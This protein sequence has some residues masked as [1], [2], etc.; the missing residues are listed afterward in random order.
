MTVTTDTKIK[1][2]HL[3]DLDSDAELVERKLKKS[4]L[5]FELLLVDNRVDFEKALSGFLPDIILSDHSL[6]NFN[7]L[8]ALQIMKDHG[9]KVPF[10]LITATV[11][12]DFAVEVMK[13]GAEDYI[14]KDR[15]QRLPAAI[16]KALEVTRLEKEEKEAIEKINK[17]KHLY[18]FISQVNQNIVHLDDEG[19]LFR[20]ACRLA[21]DFGK[22]KMAWIGLIDST[23]QSIHL[24]EQCGIPVEELALFAHA[25][26]DDNG[27]QSYV[28]RTGN[29]YISNN[30][31]HDIQLQSW[32]P[33][34]AKH[35]ICSCMVLP[36][37]KAGH[38]IGTLNLYAAELNF[39]AQEEIS[40]LIEVAADISFALDSFEKEKQH[41]IA[42]ALIIKSEKRFRH[43]LDGMMEGVQ[44]HDFNW[45]YIYVNDALVKDST[46]LK[47]QLLGHTLMEKYPGIEQTKL[48]T[49]LQRC[50]TSRVTE[51]L[52]SEF[53]FPNGTKAFFELSIQPI[54]EGIFILSINITERKKTAEKI[55]VNEAKYRSVVENIHES[56]I[57]EDAEGKLLYANNE[58]CN[59]FGFK[60]FELKKLTLKDYTSAESYPEII[61]RHKNRIE[62]LP[63]AEEFVYKGRRKDGTEIWVEA[64]VSSILEN[65]KIIGTQSLERDI[66]GRRQAE[67]KIV[68]TSRLYAFISSIN[69]SIVHVENEQELLN[70]ACTIAVNIGQF[71]MAW[72][73]LVDE[74]TGTL[75]IV[76]ISGADSTVKTAKKLSGMHYSDAKLSG[77][78]TGI[79]L[80]TGLLAVSNNLQNDP[81][82]QPWK[83]ELV[84]NGIQAGMALPIKK[85]G[86]TVGVFGLYSATENFFDEAEISLL[87]EAT[88]DISFALENFEREKKHR[89]TEELV[90]KNEKRFRSLIEKSAD[91][92]TLT[93]EEGNFMYGSPSITKVFGYSMDEFLNKPSVMFF[94]PDD[95]PGFVNNKLLIQDQPG[96]SFPFQ[97]RF[98]HKNGSWIWCEG[99]LTNMLHEPGI[100]AFVSNFRDISEK[101]KN[102]AAAGFRP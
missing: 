101:K 83:K 9:S 2:L 46:Y 92:K 27:P 33:Y 74:Q 54:P 14:L 91:M 39:A 87:E 76:S 40:L 98:L 58:F 77:T 62:G 8:Q 7:S 99:T 95:V 68:K 20:N 97:Y 56:L 71:K 36:I 47:N 65:G 75:D 60:P 32:K 41:K 16:Y 51:Q 10:I 30:V 6:V 3:E 82:M 24:V 42:E 35:G 17:A 38:I 67:D 102:R 15:L 72:I 61:A 25:P 23:N 37:K 28:V 59:M 26:Y 64:R 5:L 66:T 21:H 84:K 89:Q 85:F 55:K 79:A 70:H 94:H 96:K 11:S 43:T 88:G 80:S 100:E 81:A 50:M 57:V 4:G 93:N 34:A 19:A 86:K 45:K 90:L 73:D 48:F 29:Y 69:K 44:M 13:L 1:I 18:A 53:V 63:V 78:P 52:E 22:F 49:V 31:A 12:E